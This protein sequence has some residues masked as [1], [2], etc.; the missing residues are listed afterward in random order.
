MEKIRGQFV[1]IEAG[2]IFPAEVSIRDGKI[3]KIE[4]AAHD[5]PNYIMPGFTDAHI[6]IESSMLVPSEFARLAVLRG[7][8]ATVSDPHEIA[9]VLGKKGVEFMI[10]N[11]KK[12]PLKFH[13]GAPSCVPATE[14]ETAGAELDVDD[15]RDLMASP[16]IYYLA[17]V[18]NYPG[19]LA[20]NSEVMR[21]INWAKYFK[22]PVDGHAPGLRGE[23]AWKYA[24]AG[25]STDHECYTYEEAREKLSLGMKVII[26]EG[27][28]AKN[29]NALID[30][31][32]EHYE[33]LMFCS[34]DKH[35]DDLV[36]GH[37]NQLCAR[38]VARDIDVFKV[39]KAACINP[40]KHYNLD[41]GLLRKGDAADFIVV[42]DLKNFKVLQTFINGEKVAENGKTSIPSVAFEKPN[43]F[44]TQLKKPEEFAVKAERRDVKV[45][46]AVDGALITNELQLE[47][48]NENGNFIA[49]ID[50]DLLKI[51]VVNR[52]EDAP[53]AVA[54]IKNFGLKK[55]AIASSVA[56][57]SHNIIAVGTSDIELSNAVNHIIENKGGICAVD[58]ETAK[59][60]PLPVAGI[61]SDKDGWETGK[62]YQ[63]IDAMA[64][65]LGSSLKAPFMTLSFMALLVIPD[66]KL[67]DKGLFSGKN[68]EFV[69]L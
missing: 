24:A 56:H 44:N 42:E 57:D 47:G 38:A 31:L 28:A 11:G 15:I 21:K 62:M 64:K 41:V 17:E 25:I 65:D 50:K 9:N 52:Y 55:G 35:P 2:E 58:G 54:F 43:N 66:L 13:F 34:D 48:L 22:K 10:E 59:V 8:V 6:H 4:K 30:L 29:F 67:S 37:I 45:I 19:V 7:T 40:V 39:L 61:I 53:P 12:V 16:D 27:S 69:S 14:F 26:R 20:G 49:D 33:N 46:E 60:L 23:N 1:D 32:P 36:L 63:E 3:A 5:V 51:T 68:F 18:M